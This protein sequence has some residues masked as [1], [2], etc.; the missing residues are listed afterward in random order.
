MWSQNTL[1]KRFKTDSQRSAVLVCI[2]LSDYGTM[3]K[4]GGSVAHYLVGC[5]VKGG[6]FGSRSR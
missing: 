6:S 5:Y 1:N 3:F 2:G 4:V